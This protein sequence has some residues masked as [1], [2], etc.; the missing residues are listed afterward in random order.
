MPREYHP[1]ARFQGSRRQTARRCKTQR[2]GS[3]A[4][5]ATTV[6]KKW[7]IAAASA[8]ARIWGRRTARHLP[9]PD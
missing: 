5:A 3:E 1:T 2:G 8:V 4:V 7:L 6:K 9:K